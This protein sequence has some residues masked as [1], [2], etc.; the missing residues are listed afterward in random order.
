MPMRLTQ[1][2]ELAGGVV[3]QGRAVTIKLRY[4]GPGNVP[5]V[6]DL[7]AVMF[8]VSEVEGK[9]IEAAAKLAAAEPN[10]PL[11]EG[12]EYV[13][14]LMQ[15]SLRDPD[16]LSQP[17]LQTPGDLQAL[18]AGLVAVQYDR[19]LEE[20]RALIDQEYP[21]VVTKRHEEELEKEARGFSLS[22]QPARG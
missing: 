13:V 22:D 18:R 1:L 11:P 19:L 4:R 17:L 9:R 15:A 2:L 20:Y 14:L 5:H 16:D 3:E 12:A 7:H 6:R 10:A 8:P 21:A